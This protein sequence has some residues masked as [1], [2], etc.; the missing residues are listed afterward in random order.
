M[1]REIERK[2]LVDGPQWRDEVIASHTIR[3]G[4]LGIEVDRVVRVRVVDD[5]TGFITVKGRRTGASRAEYEYEIPYAD[6]LAMLESLCVRP[7][8]EKRRHS[9]SLPSGAWIVDEFLGDH[10]GLLLAEVELPDE[11]S[12]PEVPAWAGRE[13][14][15]DN[16]YANSAL[17]TMHGR[18]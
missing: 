13:V 2:F 14:T 6:A 18:R 9:L 17:V 1:G 12:A 4:Y 7:L 8:I 11:S 3:Q 10:H 5:T 16:A 15:T